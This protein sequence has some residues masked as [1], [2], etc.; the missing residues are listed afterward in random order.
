[1]MGSSVAK[2]T[3]VLLQVFRAAEKTSFGLMSGRGDLPSFIGRMKKALD[4]TQRHKEMHRLRVFKPQD[5]EILLD[6]KLWRVH[7]K[8][9]QILYRICRKEN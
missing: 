7:Q 9:K 2:A 4:E 1:M 5:H 8:T 3:D 6:I